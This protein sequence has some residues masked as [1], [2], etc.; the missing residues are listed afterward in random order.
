[1]YTTF[2]SV[3]F[4]QFSIQSTSR[5]ESYGFMP[6]EKEEE[7]GKM[8]GQKNIKGGKKGGRY[9]LFGKRMLYHVAIQWLKT[10]NNTIQGTQ[11]VHVMLSSLFRA[12]FR[13]RA[14]SRHQMIKGSRLLSLARGF[15][16]SSHSHPLRPWGGGKA[17]S[18]HGQVVSFILVF[19][20]PPRTRPRSDTFC[21]VLHF[22]GE[23]STSQPWGPL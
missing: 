14:A 21:F 1:M 17:R 5:L 2:S 9:V 13:S 20:F 18:V 16:G 11:V 12:E 10:Q 4:K 8:A 6:F 22:T 15:H 23:N 3:T 7:G 19:V